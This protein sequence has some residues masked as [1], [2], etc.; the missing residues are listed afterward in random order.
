MRPGC[1]GYPSKLRARV[2]TGAKGSLAV[3]QLSTAEEQ[4]GEHAEG[5][6]QEKKRRVPPLLEQ[7]AA[8]LKVLLALPDL[9]A[10]VQ[11][12]EVALPREAHS[13]HVDLGGRHELALGALALAEAD[14]FGFEAG[15]GAAMTVAG[16]PLGGGEEEGSEEEGRGGGEGGTWAREKVR[17][18]AS[19]G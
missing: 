10:R 17:P 4:Q 5:Q 1:Y 9:G 3:Q 12:Q 2:R 7:F 13:A 6:W 8:A 18:K 11:P 19:I 14:A 16:A 15:R